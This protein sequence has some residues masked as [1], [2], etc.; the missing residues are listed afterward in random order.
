MFLAWDMDFLLTNRVVVE[1]NS[2]DRSC[3]IKFGELGCFAIWINCWIGDKC[4]GY[5]SSVAVLSSSHKSFDYSRFGGTVRG[6][7]LCL[8]KLI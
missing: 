5:L 1:C 8:K 4:D 3:L 6:I 2:I 7:V